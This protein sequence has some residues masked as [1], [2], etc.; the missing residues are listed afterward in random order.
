MKTFY[1][2]TALLLSTFAS[3]AVANA[4]SAITPSAGSL[5]GRIDARSSGSF[6][7]HTEDSSGWEHPSCPSANHARVA[8]NHASHDKI[9]ALVLASKHTGKKMFFRATCHPTSTAVI[10]VVDAFQLP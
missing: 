1:L 2:I 9:Y 7:I 4:Q 3:I 10:D 5:I 8:V 6:D